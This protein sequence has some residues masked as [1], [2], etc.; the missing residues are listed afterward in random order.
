[1]SLEVK[2]IAYWFFLQQYYGIIE[3]GIGL[4][5]SNFWISNLSLY[6]KKN[7]FK[8]VDMKTIF[9]EMWCIVE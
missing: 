5:I 4:M 9:D 6:I 3:S 2:L 1:M 8:T 7:T